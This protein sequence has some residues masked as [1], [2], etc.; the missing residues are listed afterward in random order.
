MVVLVIV[1]VIANSNNRDDR[2]S[3][4]DVPWQG[5]TMIIIIIRI[6]YWQ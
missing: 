5:F 2:W 3:M 6:G 4:K 1:I